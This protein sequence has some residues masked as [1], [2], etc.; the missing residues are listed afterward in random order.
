MA[1]PRSQR[2]GAAA[3]SGRR[4]APSPS[5]ELGRPWDS[6]LLARAAGLDVA[7]WGMRRQSS[8]CVRAA[9]DSDLVTIHAAPPHLDSG[10]KAG[11]PQG[12][13]PGCLLF[14]HPRRSCRVDATAGMEPRTWLRMAPLSLEPWNAGACHPAVSKLRVNPGGFQTGR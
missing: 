9:R 12:W 1:Q 2:A 8:A 5:S 6:G 7:L 14:P 13:L 11:C 3:G 10:Q 4:E